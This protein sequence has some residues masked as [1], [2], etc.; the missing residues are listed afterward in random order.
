MSLYG[1][2]N[3]PLSNKLQIM[4]LRDGLIEYLGSNLEGIYLHGSIA[5]DSFNPGT[6]DLDI[7]VLLKNPIDIDLRFSLIRFFLDLSLKP[8][9]IEI[10][11]ITLGAVWPW[12]YPTP[13]ELHSSEY[14]RSRYE[15]Q[16]Q[17]SNKDF[18]SETP[19]DS[20]LACHIT[21]INRCGICLWGTPIEQAF[22]VVPETDFRASILS[23]VD[24][25]ANALDTMP[26]YGILTL[27]RIL[28]YLETGEILSKG[29]AGEWVLPLIPVNIRYL[30]RQAVG[31]YV[32]DV[33]GS[34]P[35]A[36]AELERY[37]LI[38]L[39]MIKR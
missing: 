12:Q 20:D 10:S 9:P 24:Y 36:K 30:V 18:W 22:P 11:L 16:V 17:S 6:S 37:K 1:W 23:D 5:L 33:D 29:L 3:C 31:I 14:W 2:H 28:S 32:G 15:E 19:V 25:A 35:F 4:K 34:A 26:V 21:L 7:I 27:S 38:M 8:S 39:S 13:F